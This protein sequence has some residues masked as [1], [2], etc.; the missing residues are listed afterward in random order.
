M[1]NAEHTPG[2]WR[3]EDIGTNCLFIKGQ[4]HIEHGASASEREY[5]SNLATVTQR[6]P[7]PRLG[8][9]IHRDVT[10][11]NARLIA[12]APELLESLSGLVALAEQMNDAS[13]EGGQ[14]D[15]R[16]DA[17][18]AALAKATGEEA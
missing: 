7:H 15:G 13:D 12:A 1:S 14:L 18:V 11:A 2:P 8:G 17:A 5:Y 4:V 9:G 3:V 10:A 6:D 16:F